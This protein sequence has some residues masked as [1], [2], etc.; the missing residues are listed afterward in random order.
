MVAELFRKVCEINVEG[1][2]DNGLR[3]A[4]IDGDGQK[5]AIFFQGQDYNGIPRISSGGYDAE[6]VIKCITA[7]RLDGAVLW[8]YGTPMGFGYWVQYGL[9]AQVSDLNGDGVPEVA[10]V[11]EREGRSYLRLLDGRRGL[12][13]KETET[14][15]NC[16]MQLCDIRGLGSRRDIL[17]S[18]YLNPIYIYTGE[19]EVLWNCHFYGGAGHH[20]DFYDI[21]GDGKEELFIGYNCVRADGTKIWW[22]PDLEPHIEQMTRSPH[23]DN[24]KVVDL[25][26]NGQID[27]LLVSGKDLICLDAAT[28]KNKWIFK[29]KHIQSVT[30]GDFLPSREGLEMYVAEHRF[31]GG[32]K[33]YLLDSNGREIW[34]REN[35]SYG[36]AIKVKDIEGD[37]IFIPYVAPGRPSL[38]MDGEG[39]ILQELDM[40]PQPTKYM[41]HGYGGSAGETYRGRA[42]DVNGDGASEIVMHNRRRLWLFEQS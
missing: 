9:A 36:Q 8:Q 30:V 33:T 15:A 32:L 18:T 5:E 21:D 37:C 3:F 14:G 16:V 25:E 31:E 22:R 26:G 24:I 42:I 7:M 17:V 28:G 27:E 13:L 23:V 6:K 10:Y 35:V 20:H 38:V 11:T 4:D 39:N 40:P 2:G 34:R 19:L 41:A 1:F 12:F 29:G